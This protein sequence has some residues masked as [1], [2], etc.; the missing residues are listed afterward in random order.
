MSVND[1]PHQSEPI[2]TQETDAFGNIVLRFTQPWYQYFSSLTQEVNVSLV[3]NINSASLTLSNT[4]AAQLAEAANN[5]GEIRQLYDLAARFAFAANDC[6]YT[7][8]LDAHPRIHTH[9]KGDIVDFRDEDYATAA[10][11][12]LADS[13]I[14]PGDN[15][16][17]LV[18]D[19]AYIT[20]PE[21]PVQ[22]VAGRTGDVVLTVP[23]VGG[24]QAA[25]DE[26]IF[27]TDVIDE[28]ISTDPSVP[29]SANQGRAL[30]VLIDNINAILA[31]DDTSL[32]EIQEIVDYIKQNREDLQD[33]SITNI[34]GLQAALDAKQAT[35]TGAASTMTSANLT[36]NRAMVTNGSGKGAAS[37]VT[38][39]ELAYVSGVTSAIQTQI[40]GKANTSHTHAI[41]DVTGLQ[42]ALDAKAAT[43]HTHAISDVTGLQ[44]ALDSKAATVHTHTTDQVSE[45]GRLYH[46]AARVLATVLAG[47][48][49]ASS[50]AV[51]AAD[52]IL[53]AIGKIQG[54]LNLLGTA[55]NANVT[56]T[57]T[58]TA[59]G[60]LLKVGDFGLGAATT[61]GNWTTP[62]PV[63]QLPPGSDIV[64]SSIDAPTS[65]AHY[66]LRVFGSSTGAFN[67]Q[68]AARGDF[69]WRFNNSATPAA[70]KKVW[71][72]TNL[73]KSEFATAAQGAKAD[74]A[75]QPGDV[76]ADFGTAA[77]AD[78]TESAASTTEGRVMQVGDYGNGLA[79]P[80]MVSGDLDSRTT[81]GERFLS[82]PAVANHPSA[83]GYAVIEVFGGSFNTGAGRHS[84][85]IRIIQRAT[86]ISMSLS[87]TRFHSGS[88]WSDWV[89]NPVIQLLPPVGPLGAGA[90][91]MLAVDDT[92]LYV[93]TA[94]NTWKRVELSSW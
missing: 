11:G 54:R 70:W 21:A 93:C 60:R 66:G 71:D 55:A 31:S 82:T 90:R 22:S 40:N 6:S 67:V 33:L 15:I 19:A 73:Q 5:Q 28:L 86:S 2:A 63:D 10:Q 51:T 26:K 53:Q 50:S 41:A 79:L 43:V 4:N 23:D 69:Y 27:Y 77:A 13:A 58:D 84:T 17:E 36:A 62:L 35:I 38:S 87:M 52:T 24:L 29:L 78:L 32:D 72:S 85:N 68:M 16:S 83:L 80:R 3:Q 61:R 30:K 18:N 59:T 20:A 91:G 12:L 42:A 94:T 34:A 76:P 8:D 14:Q 47:F 39:T 64:V 44:S 74:T 46:T 25:L 49:T 9:G 88:V 89:T 45:G 48:S 56:T 65:V 37:A 92:H 75:L 81:L 1:K 57:D 7:P